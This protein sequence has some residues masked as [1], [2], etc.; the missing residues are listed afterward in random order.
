MSTMRVLVGR[1]PGQDNV[2]T[3]DRSRYVIESGPL[4]ASGPEQVSEERK[5]LTTGP[6]GVEGSVD[7]ASEHLESRRNFA[8]ARIT[9]AHGPPDIG[10]KRGTHCD[11]PAID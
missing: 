1:G 11:R 10:R 3:C 2:G 8:A 6:E 9:L 4:R 7:A 5:P